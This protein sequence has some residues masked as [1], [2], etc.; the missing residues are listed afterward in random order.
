VPKLKSHDFSY[1]QIDNER[2]QQMRPMICSL[3]VLSAMA[4]ISPAAEPAK[5]ENRV[6]E[7]RTYTVPPGK[8]KELH[9]RF[10]DN[11]CKIM[12]KHGM[13][14]IGFWVPSDPKAAEEVLICIVAHPSQEAAK[15]A[16]D[17]LHKD[18]A[19]VKEKAEADKNGPTISKVEAKFFNATDYSKIK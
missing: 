14:L 1:E 3:L 11:I 17:E 15:K 18:P 16:W 4:L 2:E 10:R 8:M 12:E 7:M 9:A 19:Y 6:F 5:S 13:T